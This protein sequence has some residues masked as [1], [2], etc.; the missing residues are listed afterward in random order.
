MNV[1]MGMFIDD[2]SLLVQIFF[3]YFGN[4]LYA[5]LCLKELLRED[6]DITGWLLLI[7]KNKTVNSITITKSWSIEHDFR[8][9]NKIQR[10]GAIKGWLYPFKLWYYIFDLN[11][12]FQENKISW[13]GQ[14]YI[15]YTQK[16]HKILIRGNI[17]IDI[18]SGMYL[19]L[20]KINIGKW[21]KKNSKYNNIIGI[22]P[23]NEN[24]LSL[25]LKA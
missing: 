23:W 4:M 9:L 6:L 10:Q 20:L 17:Y 22:I 11:D 21:E 5:Y 18:N 3:V 25:L 15:F 19:R 24:F 8:N 2:C 12:L 16:N 7:L 13:F 1:P 14:C